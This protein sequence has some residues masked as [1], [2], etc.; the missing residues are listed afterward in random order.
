MF[1]LF[2]S[3]IKNNLLRIIFYQVECE[4][5]IMQMEDFVYG[6][7]FIHLRRSWAVS[8]IP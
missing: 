1:L 4:L 8:K 7:H 2:L 3:L 6:D 5:F